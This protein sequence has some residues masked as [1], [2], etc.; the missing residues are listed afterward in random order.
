M[1]RVTSTLSVKSET[2]AFERGVRPIQALVLPGKA[3]EVLS[4]TPDLELQARIDELAHKSNEGQLTEDEQ[5]EY[6]G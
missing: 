5:S 1:N 2:L 3:H 4:F 6:A